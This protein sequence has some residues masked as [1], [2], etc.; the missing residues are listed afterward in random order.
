MPAITVNVAVI[1][2]DKILLAKREDFEI[3]CLPSGAVEEGEWVTAGVYKTPS[4]GLV[5]VSLCY[6]N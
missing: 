3:W 2:Q 6:R 4:A 5:A 1:D